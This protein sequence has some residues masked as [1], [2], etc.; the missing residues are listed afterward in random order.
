[1]TPNIIESRCSDRNNTKEE[2]HLTDI[3]WIHSAFCN[4][5]VLG[6]MGR[7]TVT[8]KRLK[9]MHRRALDHAEW[10]RFCEINLALMRVS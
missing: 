5:I 2:M 6:I 1:M 7:M 4:S 3:N 10:S 8:E 9:C